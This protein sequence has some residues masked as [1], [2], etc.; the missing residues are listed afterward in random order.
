M[1]LLRTSWIVRI[2]YVFTKWDDVPIKIDRCTL[3]WRFILLLFPWM[4]INMLAWF[5]AGFCLGL[6]GQPV[7]RIGG[8]ILAGKKLEYNPTPSGT[9]AIVGDDLLSRICATEYSWRNISWLDWVPKFTYEGIR[10]PLLLVAELAF[11][12]WII[13]FVGYGT[14]G[15]I[16]S[17][18]DTLKTVGSYATAT[19]GWG[20]AAFI[21]VALLGLLVIYGRKGY[22]TFAATPSGAVIVAHLKAWKE[23]HCTIIELV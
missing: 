3:W 11:F 10:S 7:A 20:V 23:Q 14:I 16:M 21:G 22:K 15:M 5:I 13:A 17:F 8:F 1:T 2:A 9:S 4:F 6:V 18:P 12:I 19:V